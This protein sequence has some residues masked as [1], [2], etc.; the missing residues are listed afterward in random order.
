[1]PSHFCDPFAQ[2]HPHMDGNHSHECAVETPRVPLYKNQKNI[3]TPDFICKRV[4]YTL[5]CTS[6]FVQPEVPWA[7]QVSFMHSY[8]QPKP[9]Q[10]D[11]WRTQVFKPHC[12]SPSSPPPVRFVFLVLGM[13]PR[14]SCMPAKDFLAKFVLQCQICKDR[15]PSF[16]QKGLATSGSMTQWS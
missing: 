11:V 5:L 10:L 14:A 15:R 16:Q 3:H 8:M 7:A 1:M 9:L 6:A 12:Y 2:S 13:E 4:N